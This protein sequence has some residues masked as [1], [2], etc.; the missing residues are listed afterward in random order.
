VTALLYTIFFASGASALI[1]ETLWFRQAGLAFGNSVWASSLVLSGFMGGLALG[2]AAAARY[3]DRLRNP[4]RTYAIAES[5]IAVTGVGLVYLFPILGSALAPWFRGLLDQPWALNPLRLAIAFL[6]LLIPSTAMGITLP[7]LCGALARHD[8][9]ASGIGDWIRHSNSVRSESRNRVP[10]PESFG[11]V[12]GRLYGWNTL[13]AMFGVIIG[14]TYLIGAFGVRGTALLAGTL[15][16]F[17]AAV[18]AWLSVRGS[19]PGDDSTHISMSGAD[20]SGPPRRV[21]ESGYH[22]TLTPGTRWL[23][24]AFLSGFC[25]LALEVVWFRFLVL[26]V[27][28]HSNAFPV[29]LGIV[30]AGISLGGLVASLWFRAKTTASVLR[31]TASSVALSAGLLCVIGYAVFPRFIAPLALSTITRPLE[32][33]QSACPSCFL[34]PCCRGFLHAYRRVRGHLSRK[35]TA[36]SSRSP[37]PRVRAWVP[38]RRIC[39]LPVLN[40]ESFF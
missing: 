5:A 31:A 37:I 36:E 17:A 29:M 32:I 16:M 12:L 21:R 18:A 10:N 13:G 23:A 28:G 14:E 7:L 15:N 39:L 33:L 4:V 40:G 30:L 11:R 8:A 35:R 24:A 27:K 25:L 2:N 6:L 22:P 9:D 1:F 38:H 34:C 20:L 26:F 3:G 19:E